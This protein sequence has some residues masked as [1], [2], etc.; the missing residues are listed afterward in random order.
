MLRYECSECLMLS[1]LDTSHVKSWHSRI[2]WFS[3]HMRL[4]RIRLR[5]T[6]ISSK[7]QHPDE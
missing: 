3:Y 2:R 5:A 1:R 4:D 6:M 7:S